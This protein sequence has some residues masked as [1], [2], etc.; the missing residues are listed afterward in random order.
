[1]RVTC[2]CAACSAHTKTRVL[3]LAS[4]ARRDKTFKPDLLARAR[5]VTV[6]HNVSGDVAALLGE[7]KGAVGAGGLVREGDV[8]VCVGIG[9][10][11]G[12]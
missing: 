12:V 4:P 7:L 1:V 11:V 5:Q 8:E 9:V 2:A 10:G 3:R 6:I